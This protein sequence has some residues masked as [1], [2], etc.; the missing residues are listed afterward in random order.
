MDDD[1]WQELTE[2]LDHMERYLVTLGQ[3]EGYRYTPYGARPGSQAYDA[4]AAFGQATVAPGDMPPVPPDLVAMA[5]AGKAIQAIKLYREMTGVS[6]KD[7][8]FAVDQAA[9]MYRGR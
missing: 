8:K 6:L 7:A 9:G 1:R 2:R 3:V 4:A 5:R